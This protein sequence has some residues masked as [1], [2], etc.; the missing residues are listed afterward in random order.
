VH[1]RILALAPPETRGEI[2]RVIA[3][4]A[5]SIAKAVAA[6]RD[7]TRAEELVEAMEESGQ[8]DEGALL[9]F[10]N[11]RKYEEMTVALARLCSAPLKMISGLMMGLR[12]DAILVPCKAADLK[13]P[14]RRSD[15]AQSALQS[16]GPGADHRARAQRL[17]PPVGCDR[18]ANAPL[19]AGARSRQIAGLQWV[20]LGWDRHRV[21]KAAGRQPFR[22]IVRTGCLEP[23]GRGG[24]RPR[25]W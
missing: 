11:R 4:T 22:S 15:P 13:W 16:S 17:R 10:V 12:N 25:A 5:R 7:F 19:H 24:R 9:E 23:P 21:H 2:Q 20:S 6:E 18:P 1:T 14:T 8:L 3:N